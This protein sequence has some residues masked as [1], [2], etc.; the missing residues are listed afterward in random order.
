MEAL[1]DAGGVL[2]RLA[3]EETGEKEVA[4]GPDGQILVEINVVEARQQAP[5]LQLEQCGGDQQ[6]LGG[7]IQ[8]EVINACK[9]DEVGV[10]DG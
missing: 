8:V 6:E 2:E 4:L 7:E 10:E 1:E 3:L 5:R 9:I